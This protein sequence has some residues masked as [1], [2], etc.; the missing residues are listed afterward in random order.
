MTHGGRAGF[1]GVVGAAG[2]GFAGASGSVKVGTTFYF[3]R[4]KF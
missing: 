1:A 3:F 2:F 4:G